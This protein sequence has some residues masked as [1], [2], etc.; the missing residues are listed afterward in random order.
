MDAL[1]GW[2]GQAARRCLRYVRRCPGEMYLYT[3]IVHRACSAGT[4]VLAVCVPSVRA[5]RNQSGWC[6]A[7]RACDTAF[8]GEALGTERSLRILQG[9][10]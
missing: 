8:A 4:A 7:E 10:V 3:H 9:T 1:A 5:R 6:T 2:C